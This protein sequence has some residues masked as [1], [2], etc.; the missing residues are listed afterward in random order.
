MAE[1]GWISKYGVPSLIISIAALSLQQQQ[2]TSDRVLANTQSGW[3][4]YADARTNLVYS[5]EVD[6]ELYTLSV[7]GAA[8]PNIYCVVRQDLFTRAADLQASDIAIAAE[9]RAPIDRTDIDN[10][11]Q[12]ILERP[13]PTAAQLPANFLQAWATQF[14]TPTPRPCDPLGDDTLIAS[15]DADAGAVQQEPPP[16]PPPAPTATEELAVEAAPAP[17]R[18]TM[19]TRGAGAGPVSAPADVAVPSLTAAPQLMRVFFHVRADSPYDANIAAGAREALTPYNFRVM[20]QVERV[21]ARTFPAQA[22]IRYNGSENGRI[23]AEQLATYLNAQY[24]AYGITFRL[25]GEGAWT[26]RLPAQNL[27]VWIPNPP[28]Q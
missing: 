24:A 17:A 2:Q 14:S 16:P 15:N 3:V 25:N 19:T 11:L 23:A 8:F 21:S 5:D 12:T 20:R 18:R 13:T 7:I 22:E 9:G 28:Q 4:F 1:G 27:E 6:R 26:A 10:L